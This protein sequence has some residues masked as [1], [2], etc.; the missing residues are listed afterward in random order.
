ML[1][2]QLAKPTAHF[3]E[4]EDHLFTLGIYSISTEPDA[5]DTL[6]VLCENTDA[7]PD[8]LLTLIISQAEVPNT[9]WVNQWIDSYSGIKISE[10][11]AIR[12]INSLL[13]DSGLV[14]WMD[15][16]DAF[17][18]GTH[19]TT[20]L[21]LVALESYLTTIATHKRPA[22]SLLDV[23]T[24]TGVLAILASKRGLTQVHAIDIDADSIRQTLTNATLNQCPNITVEQADIL[25][26]S[27]STTDTYDIIVANV[28]TTV[29]LEALPQLPQ[30]LKPN[31]HLIL[32]GMSTTNL[33]LVGHKLADLQLIATHS[34]HLD[35]WGCLSVK[36]DLGDTLS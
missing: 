26:L 9:D 33:P 10:N 35:G 4:I 11:L 32:S 15:P 1:C 30:A 25:T 14:L 36:R 13:Q 3:T 17:G 27:P 18:S 29:L 5:P 16:R 34:S 19:P 24:G 22:L 6:I 23:G 8:H 28:I 21:C 12:P 7:W 31:G 2:I 20:Q